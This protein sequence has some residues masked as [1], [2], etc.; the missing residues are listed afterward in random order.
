MNIKKKRAANNTGQNYFG[1][2]KRDSN[3]FRIVCETKVVSAIVF[4]SH[5]RITIRGK[6]T[7]CKDTF[8]TLYLFSVHIHRHKI[9]YTENLI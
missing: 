8:I 6:V 5:L 9:S 4:L 1:H 7:R 3:F 2:T